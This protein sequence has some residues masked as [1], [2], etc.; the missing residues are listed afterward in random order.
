MSTVTKLPGNVPLS[1]HDPE[2]YDLIEQVRAR[3]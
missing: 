3:R 2:M 1:E